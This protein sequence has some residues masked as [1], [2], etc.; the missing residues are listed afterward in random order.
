L[1]AVYGVDKNIVPAALDL[2]R[3]NGKLYGVP[4]K[5]R[6]MTIF[7]KK[8]LFDK[9][10]LTAPKTFDELEKACETLKSKGITPFSLEENSVG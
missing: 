5:V 1:Q 4:F 6:P 8:S 2:A 10:G 3:H 9:C 7:Y